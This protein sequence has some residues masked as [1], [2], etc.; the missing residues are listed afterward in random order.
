MTDHSEEP[1][2]LAFEDYFAQS[3]SPVLI[4]VHVQNVA[5]RDVDV[6]MFFEEPEDFLE[7]DKIAYDLCQGRILDIGAGVGRF[8][9]PLQAKGLSTV[10]IEH[11]SQAV[12]IMQ[13]K[14]LHDVYCGELDAF[15]EQ[16][17]AKEKFDTILMMMNGL[18]IVGTLDKLERFFDQIKPFI[19][20]DGQILADSTDVYLTRLNDFSSH[21]ER[22]KQ[23]NKYP[24]EVQFKFEYKDVVGSAMPWLHIDETTLALLAEKKGWRSDVIY[25]G[26]DGEYLTRL[27]L[28]Q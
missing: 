6:S 18:G 3:D 19:K 2:S 4:K 14:G 27:T 5:V 8:S 24:G 15:L 22:Q 17:W 28:L 20:P 21:I 11:S 13:Q 7:I 9:L 10:A 1:I 25:R 23:H 26:T 12:A 16:S